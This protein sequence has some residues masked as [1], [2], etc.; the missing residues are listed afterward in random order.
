VWV[1]PIDGEDDRSILYDP[2][3][4]LAFVGNEVMANVARRHVDRS[5]RRGRATRAT[6]FLD[7]IGF[8]ASRAPAPRPVADGFRP[9]SVVL[10]TTNRCQLRC[11][12]CYAAAGERPPAELSLAR[13]AA[14]IDVVAAIAREDGRDDFEVSFHGGGEPTMAWR[15]VERATA[16]ARVKAVPARITL[17]SNA[18]WTPARCR[19]IVENV[20]GL[21]VSVDGGPATQDRSRPFANGR[22]SSR[23]VMRNLGELDRHGID[24]G[25]RMTAVSP[26]NTLAADVRFLLE[27]T[28]GRVLRVEPAFGTGRGGHGEPTRREVDGFVGSFLAA[29]DVARELGGDLRYTGADVWSA[30]WSFCSAP[31]DALIVTPAGDVVTCY[32]VV[33]DRHPL[34]AISTVGHLDPGRLVHDRDKRSA[35]RAR[36]AD[37]RARCVDCYCFWTCAGDCYV[38]AF[39]PGPDGH[40]A[41]GERCRMNR[42]LTSELLLRLIAEAGGVWRRDFVPAATVE[43]AAAGG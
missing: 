18:V 35:L 22:G 15:L 43:A 2:L 1:V 5:L 28:R 16:H 24:Y 20:D 37:R 29:W 7:E 26:W 19:W 31:E 17:T 32:E 12:Y 33:D 39:R 9:R 36:V 27:H 13:A 30:R 23:I 3:R 25:L 10:L 21:T 11:R 42:T 38:R 8:G 41:R 6:R 34:A 40:L 4:G 14:A